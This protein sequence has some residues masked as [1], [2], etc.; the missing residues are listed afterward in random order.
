MELKMKQRLYLTTCCAMMVFLGLPGHDASALVQE[1]SPNSTPY[2]VK[3]SVRPPFDAETFWAKL[4]GLI[5]LHGGYIEPAEV[6]SFFG[7]KVEKKINLGD[8]GYRFEMH[9]NSPWSE[10]IDYRTYF[11]EYKLASQTINPG[12]VRS[13]LG[14]FWGY[15]PGEA[16]MCI[17]PNSMRD[18]LLNSGWKLAPREATGGEFGTYNYYRLVSANGSS[19]GITYGDGRFVQDQISPEN[20]CVISVSIFG[21]K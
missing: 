7:V 16:N 13:S 3:P 1:G 11:K 6:E 17:K 14:V 8:A 10:N 18:S 20:S 9:G 4:N 21:R 2:G 12:G 19:V 15:F 5:Q